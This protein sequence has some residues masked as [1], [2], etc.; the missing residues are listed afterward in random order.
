MTPEVK[1]RG[2]RLPGS[3]PRRDATLPPF[4]IDLPYP[5]IE[6]LPEFAGRIDSGALSHGIRHYNGSICRV[7]VRTFMAYRVESYRAISSVAVCE[8]SSEFT[9]IHDQVLR[10]ATDNPETHIEDPH[11]AAIDG[12]LYVMVANVVRGFP[13]ICRQRLFK[14]DQDTLEIVAEVDVPFGTG[15]EKNWTPFELPSGGIG[16]VYKQRPR[17]VIEAATKRGFTTPE[18]AVAPKD[19]SLSGRT[20]PLR[21]S[22]DHYLEFVGGHVK[23]TE[24]RRG[25]RYWFGA[26][27]FEAR[28][29]YNVIGWTS[30]PLVW[31]SEASPTIFNPMPGGGHPVCILPAG[32]ILE[33]NGGLHVLVSCGV[34]DS[35]IALLRFDLERLLALLG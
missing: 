5:A 15:V 13:S 11:M 18:V 33:E 14:V 6:D 23:F 3:E 35:Y 32:A 7:G 29:P 16:I 10:P 12:R 24:T 34:N 8:L 27:L 26:V 20:S 19:S 28:E 25:T 9:V 22:A 30:E 17:Q 21:I 2:F 31:A 4:C 1:I